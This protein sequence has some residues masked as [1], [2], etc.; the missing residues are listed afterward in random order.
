MQNVLFSYLVYLEGSMKGL[1]T[2][3]I[4][5]DGASI[6][7]T[8]TKLNPIHEDC[9]QDTNENDRNQNQPQT[10]QTQQDRESAS[11][12]VKVD[13]KKLYACL[14]WQGTLHMVRDISSAVLC[15]WENEMLVLDVSL[16]PDLGRFMYYV[17]VHFLSN[18][19]T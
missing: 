19:W 8:F 15:M 3:Q 14:H 12:T 10:T 4:D 9:K 6:R 13:S 11:C 17:P 1:L 18:D 7:T 2:F 5:G 16:N